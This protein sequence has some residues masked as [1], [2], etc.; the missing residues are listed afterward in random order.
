MQNYTKLLDSNSG[1][2]DDKVA[3]FL[4]KILKIMFFLLD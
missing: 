4:Y 1:R 3:K 2:S